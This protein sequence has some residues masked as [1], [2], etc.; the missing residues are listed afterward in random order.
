MEY[1]FLFTPGFL[2]NPQAGADARPQIYF[3]ERSSAWP[4]FI[5]SSCHEMDGAFHLILKEKQAL[6]TKVV[7]AALRGRPRS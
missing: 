6:P 2:G 7:G 4:G 3:A 5:T 1:A